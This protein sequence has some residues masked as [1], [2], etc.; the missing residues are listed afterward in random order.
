[1]SE[2]PAPYRATGNFET[3]YSAAFPV[4]P[5]APK[6][7]P[8]HVPAGADWRERESPTFTMLMPHLRSLS[9]VVQQEDQ[10]IFLQL[11]ADGTLFVSPDL[12]PDEAAR[13]FLDQLVC[14]Y[15]QWLVQLRA[16]R[17]ER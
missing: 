13:L 4:D 16:Q 11:R 6:R 7:E 10:K 8:L 1:M 17:D 2:Q 3:E 15:P 9:A 5:K 12:K 14:V